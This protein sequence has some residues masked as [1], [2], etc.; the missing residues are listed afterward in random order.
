L[1]DYAARRNELF[2]MTPPGRAGGTRVGLARGGLFF[3]LY[4]FW[5][6]FFGSLG[7]E[8]VVS[9]SNSRDALHQGKSQLAAELCYPAEVLVGHHKELLDRDLDFVFLPEVIDLEP[10]PWA[11][12]W[13]RPQS[14]PLLQSIRGAVVGSL[15]P[16]PER[17]VCAEVSFWRGRRAVQDQLRAVAKRLLGSG[18]SEARLHGAVKAAYR[19]LAEYE[20]KMETEGQA[21]IEGLPG[22]LTPGA[23]AAVFIG[24]SYTLYDEDV[25]KRAMAHALRRGILAIPQD[26][27]IAYVRG[28]YEGRIRSTVLG[29]REDFDRE[30]GRLL[31]QMDHVYPAQMQKMLSAA[32]IA[33]YLNERAAE[34]GLPRLHLILQDP[35]KCGPNAMLRHYLDQV[36]GYLRLTMDEHTAPAGM[37]TRLEAYRSTCRGRERFEAPTLLSA[38]TRGLA[39][40]GD[41]EILVADASPHAAVFVALFRSHGLRASLLPRNL[42]RDHALARDYVNGDECLPMIQNV[43]DFL[44]YLHGDGSARNG[45]AAFFQAWSCGPCRYGL[46]APTQSLVLNRAGFGGERICSVRIEDLIKQLGLGFVAAMFDGVLATD[47]LQKMLLTTRPYENQPGAAEGAFAES[48]AELFD[49]L[50][51]TRIGVADFLRG[52]HLGPF[53]DLLRTAAARFARVDRTE[54]RRPKIIVA[55]EFYVRLD[56]RCCQDVVRRIEAAGGEALLSPAAEFLHYTAF[57][58][59]EEGRVEAAQTW[60]PAALLRSLMFAGLSSL[61]ERDEGRLTAAAGAVL[62]EPS[63]RE[64][65]RLSRADVPGLYAGELPMTIGRIRALAGRGEA[66]GVVAVAPFNCMRG[67]ITECHL[68]TLREELGLPMISLYYDGNDNP[69]RDEFI[70]SLVFQARSRQT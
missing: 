25:S 54:S 46:Y 41:R 52:A 42:D 68:S 9:D 14:C 19:A 59:G 18:F 31:E 20:R 35:F 3:D 50:S 66:Q 37:I 53:E 10:L 27:L 16:D 38:R 33:N 11:A 12:R 57:I 17:L 22:D 15:R 32:F 23:I 4:P 70:R 29:R 2:Y 63:P 39:A 24:R 49:L 28:W 30:I 51:R 7:A 65:R 44:A 6:G 69:G 47:L 58:S 67:L 56:D 64:L 40:L 26:F 21:V 60:R 34:T 55:G 43:Q 36:S 48:L 5:A 1:P 8:V 13:P 62:H 45:D 61:G